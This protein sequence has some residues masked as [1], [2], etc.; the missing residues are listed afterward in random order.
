MNHVTLE[1]FEDNGWVVLE[2]ADGETFNV[3]RAWVPNDAE[4]GNVLRLELTP[5]AEMS[6][7]T[8]RIDPEETERRREEAQA[9]YDATPKVGEGDL[10][11]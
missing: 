3:P 4:E 10:D 2:R 6:Q 11:L 7:V 5:D 9:W 8:M 1:R